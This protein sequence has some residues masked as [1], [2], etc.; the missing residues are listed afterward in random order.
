M[1]RPKRPRG[2][3]PKIIIDFKEAE[4]LCYIQ[5]TETE[6][7]EWF[8]C[9]VDTIAR[10]IREKYGISF[11]EYFEKH[12]VGGKIALRRNLFHL[13]ENH[14]SMAIFLAKNW[15]DMK[16]RTELANPEGEAFKIEHNAKAKLISA[17]DRLAARARE[18]EDSEQP[19]AKGD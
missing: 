8:H 18:A 15:L 19:E 1:A 2:H 7:A 3:R 10:R 9:S 6:L 16:D 14:P 11:A 5:C 13:A 17:L 12:R 4:K